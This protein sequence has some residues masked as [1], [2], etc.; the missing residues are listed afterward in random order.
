MPICLLTFN[1]KIK[2]SFEIIGWLT[3][4]DVLSFF[5]SLFLHS[6]TIIGCL[7][8]VQYGYFIIAWI[9]D[10]EPSFLVTFFFSHDQYFNDWNKVSREILQIHT[11]FSNL[12]FLVFPNGWLYRQKKKYT[13]QHNYLH[14]PVYNFYIA[15]VV[16]LFW[17]LM[18]LCNCLAFHSCILLLL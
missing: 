3:H 18:S 8:T 11:I 2:V 7:S 13:W 1:P 9:V 16:I 12:N 17:K 15:N 5:L 10:V 4:H 6:Y 14:E